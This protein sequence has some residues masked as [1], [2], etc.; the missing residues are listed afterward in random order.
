MVKNLYGITSSRTSLRLASKYPALDSVNVLGVG[1][2]CRK[3]AYQAFSHLVFDFHRA[4]QYTFHR[5]MCGLMGSWV[6]RISRRLI[7]PSAQAGRRLDQAAA[8]LLADYSRSRLKVWIESGALTL[9]GRRA[10]PKTPVREGE[11]IALDVTL[12]PVIP[13]QPQAIP[14]RVIHEDPGFFIVDKPANLVVHPGAGNPSGTLQ[15][16][17]LHLDPKLAGVPRAGIVHRLDKDTSGLLVVARTLDAHKVLVRQLERREVRR[18][19]EAVCQTVLTGGG[20]IDAAIARH[21]TIRLRMAAGRGGRPALTRYRVIER[22]R[23]HTHVRVEPHTGRTHQIRVHFSH[24]RAPLTGD[25]LYGGRPRLPKSPHPRLRGIL[26]R[27]PRQALHAR[28]LEF[29]HPAR[30]VGDVSF[31]SPLPADF[32]VLIEALRLDASAA[33]APNG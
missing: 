8:E 32:R 23:A 31:E 6:D 4:G 20:E 3:F 13:L 7:I 5:R 29:R 22:F 21:P 17:L 30:A 24:I 27:F 19:Y 15:N 14:L 28:R 26:Q 2:T 1:D 11:E 12:E 16:A 18:T 9:S 33:S 25:P 10:E